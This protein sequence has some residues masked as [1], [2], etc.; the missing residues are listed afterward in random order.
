LRYA[1][2]QTQKAAYPVTAA[3]EENDRK[4]YCRSL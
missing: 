1:P 2:G 3:G 4:N